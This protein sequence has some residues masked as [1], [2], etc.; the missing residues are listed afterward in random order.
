MD[1][2]KL[3][4]AYADH[5]GVSDG[6]FNGLTIEEM[7]NGAAYPGFSDFVAGWK[8][9]LKAQGE[10]VLTVEKEPDY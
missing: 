9:A 2:E 8:R 7:R 5:C 4:A 10:P 1:E 6:R 3:I